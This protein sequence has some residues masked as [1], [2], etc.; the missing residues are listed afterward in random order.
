MY[1]RGHL[2]SRIYGTR[3]SRKINGSRI[4]MELQYIGCARDNCPPRVVSFISRCLYIFIFG[5]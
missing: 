4:L 5:N 1:I 3:E 2:I